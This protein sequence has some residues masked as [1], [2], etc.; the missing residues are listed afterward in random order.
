MGYFEKNKFQKINFPKEFLEN[1]YFWHFIYPS[2]PFSIFFECEFARDF[3]FLFTYRGSSNFIN[4]FLCQKKDIACC[5]YVSCRKENKNS[6][7]KIVLNLFLYQRKDAACCSYVY[8]SKDNKNLVKKLYLNLFLYQRK[9]A[10]CCSY[11]SWSK[12]NKN[13]VEKLYLYLFKCQRKDVQLAAVMF[14][15]VMRIKT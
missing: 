15:G 4:L 3:I 13:L 7:Q 11:V 14:L 8:C 10:A 9:D 6:V 1:D 5:S 12:D 2:K